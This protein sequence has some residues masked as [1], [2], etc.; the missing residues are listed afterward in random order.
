LP[1]FEQRKLAPSDWSGTFILFGQN[2][3]AV[4]KG[5]AYPVDGASRRLT[6][7]LVLLREN[8]GCSRIM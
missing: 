4:T 6:G 7:T 2:E 1:H 5:I 3:H 8:L